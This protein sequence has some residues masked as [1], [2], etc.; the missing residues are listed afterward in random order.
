MIEAEPSVKY[1]RNLLEAKTRDE[2]NVLARK[3][4]LSGHSKLSKEQLVNRI[5]E[6]D[7][8]VLARNLSVNWW[9]RY[10]N[11]VYGAFT[12]VGVALAVLF[13]MVQWNG[14]GTQPNV[15]DADYEV[16]TR[17]NGK[18]H[19]PSRESPASLSVTPEELKII[20]EDDTYSPIS[21]D[22]FFETF[23]DGSLTKLQQDEFANSLVNRRIVWEGIVKSVE[24]ERDGVI[25]ILI[26]PPDEDFKTAFLKFDSRMKSDLLRIKT[27]QRIRATGIVRNIISSPFVRDCQILKVTEP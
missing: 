24:P 13:F 8:K 25:T 14:R 2:L 10:H 4:N 7:S 6:T 27:G 18:D 5:L 21:L 16:A 1:H 26:H 9:D 19:A 11:H 12:V 22:Q 3:L 23:F 20:S 15:G 17:D